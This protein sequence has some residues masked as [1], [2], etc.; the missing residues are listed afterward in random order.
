MPIATMTTATQLR[1]L[2]KFI[3]DLKICLIAPEICKGIVPA[4]QAKGGSGHNSIARR[5]AYLLTGLCKGLRHGHV[6]AVAAAVSHQQASNAHA[7]TNE[8]LQRC[9]HVHKTVAARPKR[10]SLVIG[11]R[12]R[13]YAFR[14]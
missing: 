4:C 5:P 13:A 6:D 7:M 2:L 11:A 9:E 10:A 8:T 14:S 1:H 12:N 3:R